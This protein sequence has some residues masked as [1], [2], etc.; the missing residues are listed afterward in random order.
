[1]KIMGKYN[2]RMDTRETAENLKIFNTGTRDIR[3]DKIANGIRRFSRIFQVTIP[4]P[5]IHT[6]PVIT[7]QWKK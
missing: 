2:H 6:Y 7:C 5:A 4:T 1:M 3:K